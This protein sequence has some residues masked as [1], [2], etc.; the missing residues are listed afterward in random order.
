M[1]SG[2]EFLIPSLP[3][4]VRRDDDQKLALGVWLYDTLSRLP[5]VCLDHP[6]ALHDILAV[7]GGSLEHSPKVDLGEPPVVHP[8]EQVWTEFQLPVPPFWPPAATHTPSPSRNVVPP[9]VGSPVLLANAISLELGDAFVRFCISG[10]TDPPSASKAAMDRGF[11]IR[12][13]RSGA[14]YLARPRRLAVAG[15]WGSRGHAAQNEGDIRSTDRT[16]VGGAVGDRGDTAG[17]FAHART[18]GQELV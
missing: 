6:P 5:A 17:R 9:P 1:T 3:D 11:A 4:R 14:R 7:A 8:L 12:I 18:T 16:E 13:A 10:L 2:Y 15:L